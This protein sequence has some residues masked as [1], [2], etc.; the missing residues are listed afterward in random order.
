MTP[1]SVVIQQ[2]ERRELIVFQFIPDIDT[3]QVLCHLRGKIITFD[4]FQS[5]IG[6]HRLS[7]FLPMISFPGGILLFPVVFIFC[8]R[9]RERPGV[10]PSG[11]MIHEV[12]FCRFRFGVIYIGRHRPVNGIF[13]IVP[14]GTIA[15]GTC[16]LFGVLN[17]SRHRLG[18]GFF[19]AQTDEP[20]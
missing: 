11:I 3:R 1:G 18:N 9:I 10:I 17:G 8:R 13:I 7:V 2:A 15:E 19:L 16:I 20:A 12:R 4:H 14:E 6:R 5:F